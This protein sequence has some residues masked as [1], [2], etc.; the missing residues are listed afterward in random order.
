[1]TPTPLAGDGF[2]R[3]ECKAQSRS[4]LAVAAV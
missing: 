4:A 3:S 2:G 1:M